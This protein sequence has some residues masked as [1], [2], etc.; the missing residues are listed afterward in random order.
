VSRSGERVLLRTD[1]ESIACRWHGAP[2]GDAAVLWVF[3]AGGGFG[4]PAGGLYPRLAD[5]LA[6]D[7]VASLELAYRHPGR[8]DALRRPARRFAQRRPRRFAS[9]PAP[10]YP[11]RYRATP[12]SRCF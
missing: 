11:C 10:Y 8:R 4:G 12:Q 6:P 3:G 9:R 1:A 5:C 7:R 2:G